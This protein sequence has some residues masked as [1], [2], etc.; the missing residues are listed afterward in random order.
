MAFMSALLPSYHNS[1]LK[2]PSRFFQP[3]PSRFM[4]MEESSSLSY[5]LGP[6]GLAS[7]LSWAKP[8]KERELR[9]GWDSASPC[10]S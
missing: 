10:E 1:Q 3:I 7:R 8:S 6:Q 5:D 4:H 2:I 9:P